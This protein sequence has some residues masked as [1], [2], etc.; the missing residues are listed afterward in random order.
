[1]K[2]VFPVL[3]ALL[4]L[5][6]CASSSRAEEPVRSESTGS[7]E[8]AP[9]SP[10]PSP[11]F[12]WVNLAIL[13]GGMIYL[14]KKPAAEFFDSRK[15]DI[16]DGLRKAETAHAESTRRMN[17]IEGRLQKLSSE[18]AA[19]QTQADTESA[20]E[21]EKILQEAKH[22]MERLVEQSHHE[23]DR[24]ARS[25]ERNIR[26]KIADAVVDRASRTLET[27]ITEDDQKRVVVR[28]LDNA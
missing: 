12:K 8:E 11:I 27:Q 17:E 19:L 15:N 9:G 6:V 5:C 22:D 21:R 23:I 10:P 13:L 16:T 2:K 26:E 25:I 7:S 3:F 1:V 28:F 4:L 18:I 14:L 24:I 20:Q